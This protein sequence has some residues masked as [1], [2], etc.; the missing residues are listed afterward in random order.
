MLTIIQAISEKQLNSLKIFKEI[1]D[2]AG[3]SKCYTNLDIA[4]GGKNNLKKAN[5]Y[6]RKAKEE[7]KEDLSELSENPLLEILSKG[8]PQP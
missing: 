2:K 6:I 8:S 7:K 1:G 3:E 5:E 4:Y